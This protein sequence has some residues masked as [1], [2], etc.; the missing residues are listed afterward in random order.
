MYLPQATS[1][2]SQY[3]RLPSH[4]ERPTRA[5]QKLQPSAGNHVPSLP[6]YPTGFP[7]QPIP[8]ERRLHKGVNRIIR[9]ILEAAY[10]ITA[11][12]LLTFKTL[13]HLAPTVLQPHFIFFFL[14]PI[15]STSQASFL[16]LGGFVC[17]SCSLSLGY[18]L[19][20]PS[21]RSDLTTISPPQRSLSW[22]PSV[23]ELSIPFL[24][25]NPILILCTTL[26]HYL[27]F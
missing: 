8:R 12:K 24:S 2:P 6:Q 1:I 20:S 21:Y 16:F 13:H 9:A 11:L 5:R 25:Q 18:F 3:N 27:I 7:G 14:G 23:K 4:R 17:I 22:P 26:N 15:S 19:H 10:H